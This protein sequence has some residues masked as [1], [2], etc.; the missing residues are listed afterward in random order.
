[1]QRLRGLLFTLMLL[2]TGWT[3]AASTYSVTATRIAANFYQLANSNIML[4]TKFCFE[5]ARSSAAVLSMNSGLGFSD[6][7]ILFQSGTTCEV[8]GA[9]TASSSVTAGSYSALLSYETQSFFSD[10]LQR[11]IFQTDPLCLALYTGRT[12]FTL[13]ATGATYQYGSKIG[14]L[15]FPSYSYP[16]S[17]TLVGVYFLT[18]LSYSA[19]APA[20]VLSKLDTSL[21]GAYGIFVTAVSDTAATGYWVVVPGGSAQPS[22]TQVVSGIDA[23]GKAFAVRGSA[24]MTAGAT[25]QFVVTDLTPNTPYSF[26]LVAQNAA[27]QTSNGVGLDFKTSA[28]LTPTIKLQK[29]K[30][31]AVRSSNAVLTISADKDSEA[32][33]LVLPA[34]AAI[35]SVMQ[36]LQGA[37]AAWTPSPLRGYGP[38]KANTPTNYVLSGLQPG[39]TYNVFAATSTA[40]E[41]SDGLYAVL[42]TPGSDTAAPTRIKPETGWWWSPSEG[43]RG[44]SLESNADGKLYFAGFMY[45]SAGSPVWYVS[46]LLP[47]PATGFYTGDLQY[48]QGGQTLQGSWRAP[49]GPSN[50]GKVTLMPLSDRKATLKFESSNF[51]TQTTN[52]ERFP[53]VSDGLAQPPVAGNPQTGWWWNPNEGGRGY[54]IEVQGGTAFIAAYLYDEGGKPNWYITQNALVAANAYQGALS[55]YGKGQTLGG[56]YASP[57]VTNA[58]AGAVIVQFSSATSGQ[59]I[60]PGGITVPIQRYAF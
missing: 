48:Y 35:P 13:D 51:V 19:T 33:W 52:I 22:K 16:P 38:L 5:F 11:A 50:A 23:S 7:Q 46:W 26:Y 20:P 37:D 8:A 1:M 41:F 6:G 10:S 17:C 4:K 28:P 24:K 39:T 32:H 34:S 2:C 15:L 21:L 3:A 45:D 9:Y 31:D 57:V 44:Y 42:T 56:L 58:N 14:T 40:N 43:G 27:G 30:V 60:L 29:I 18:D 25:T 49:I 54:F 12:S 53:I 55:L 36:V 47:D 59:L